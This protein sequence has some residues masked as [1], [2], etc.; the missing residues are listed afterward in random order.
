[1]AFMRYA[2]ADIIQPHV[3]SQTWGRIRTASNSKIASNLV[4]QAGEIFGD[5]A[6]PLILRIMS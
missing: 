6:M 5:M 3:S 1:M 2:T 4:G